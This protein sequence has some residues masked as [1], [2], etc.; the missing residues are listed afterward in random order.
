MLYHISQTTSNYAFSAVELEPGDNK[1]TYFHDPL[2]F[3]LGLLLTS[4]SL[5][6]SVLFIAMNIRRDLRRRARTSEFVD[7]E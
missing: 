6:M 5:A 4:V 1:V 2:S 7:E 3:K